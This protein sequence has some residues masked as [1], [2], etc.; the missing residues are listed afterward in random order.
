MLKFQKCLLNFIPDI[1]KDVSRFDNAE[2]KFCNTEGTGDGDDDEMSL[3]MSR[4]DKL[5]WKENK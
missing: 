3:N 4:G 5:S 1:G 2:K